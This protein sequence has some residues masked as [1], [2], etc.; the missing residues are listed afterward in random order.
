MVQHSG[1]RLMDRYT[2]S[3]AGAD[4]RAERSALAR[5]IREAC[6]ADGITN[7]DRGLAR[8]V[9][10]NSAIASLCAGFE[11][12]ARRWPVGT[13]KTARAATRQRNDQYNRQESKKH[14]AD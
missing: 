9:Y 2:Q 7:L 13:K 11:D 6:R 1:R 8:D 4:Q 3:V 10:E 14:T 5:R 12:P